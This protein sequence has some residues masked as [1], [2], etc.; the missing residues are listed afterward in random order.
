M[1]PSRPDGHAGLRRL[2]QLSILCA[3]GGLVATA[4][5]LTLLPN[6]TAAGQWI[7]GATGVISSGA[8]FL[9]GMM[10]S[11]RKPLARRTGFAVV[12]VIVPTAVLFG[13]LAYV[14]PES[15]WIF[16]AWTTALLGYAAIATH[17]LV[18][19]P[20]GALS[21]EPRSSLGIFI[22]YR[23]Q[24][25][26]ETV[27]RIL[28]HLSQAFERERLFLD[29]H[30]QAPGD[31]YRTV[32]S[33]ALAQSEVVLVVIGM[34][35]L[36]AATREGRRRLDDPDDMVRIEIETA[37]ERKLR[38]VPVLV[39]GASVPPPARLPASLQPL[40]FRTAMLLRPDPDFQTDLLRLVDALRATQE[41]EGRAETIN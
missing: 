26:L 38:V 40:S 18:R 10:I 19:W 5:A 33:R 22:S 4:G 3:M 25:T 41:D 1:T 9:F 16:A 36:D 2:S 31:D 20:T 13:L 28:D 30:R 8:A 37:L 11:L 14:T 12:A 39:E 17:R 21:D 27:G 6:A 24:D 15:A 34:E 23:R 35:W 7:L 32:I 29:V